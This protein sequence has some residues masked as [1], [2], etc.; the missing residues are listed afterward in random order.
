MDWLTRSDVVLLAI[1]GYVAVM[2]LVR[3]MK[4]RHDALVA[5]LEKQISAHRGSKKRTRDSDKP[6]R[7]AA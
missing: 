3:M 5:D 7:Q 2:T 1:T 4:Q 6:G